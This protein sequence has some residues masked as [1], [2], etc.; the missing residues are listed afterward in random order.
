MNV[1]VAP[2]PT[3]PPRRHPLV[4]LL[5][6][7]WLG[8]A[9]LSLIL[10]YSSVV[11]AYAPAR[12]ALEVTEM[13]A[14]RHWLFALLVA[15]FTLSLATATFC[16]MHWRWINAGALVAH[17]GLLLLVGGAWAYF[18]TKIEGEVLLRAPAIQIRATIGGRS[19]I[20]D[21]FRASTGATWSS[22]L[23][24]GTDPIT[25]HVVETT[26][27]GVQP[28][29]AAK[30]HVHVGDAPP[31]VV[32]VGAGADDWQ[33]LTETLSAHLAT[34]AAQNGFYDD[35]TPVL[36]L[37]NLTTGAATTAVIAR[38][39]IHR[40]RYLPDEGVLRDARGTEIPSYRTRPAI[41]LLGL[42]IPT[43]WFEPWRMPID[44]PAEG[45]PFTIRITGYV[46]YVVELQ[47]H[48][49]PDG[50]SRML[51]TLEVRETRQQGISPRAASA[52]RLQITGTGD[53]AGWTDTQWCPFSSY[54]EVN[55]HPITI[56]APDGRSAWEVLYTRARHN[57]GAT[58]AA[59]RVS[60]T[61]FPGQRGIESYRSDVY[62]QTG[63]AAPRAATVSTNQ[64]LAI[65]HWTLFQSGFDF[66]NHWEYTVLGVGNQ[67]GIWPMNIGWIIVTLGCLFAFY[68]KPALLRRM[69]GAALPVLLI[70]LC[71]FIPACRKPV[72]PF[73]ASKTAITL[74]QK[75]DWTNARLIV[76]QDGGRYKTLD[77]FAR[78]SFAAMTGKEH[79]PGLT[80]AASLLEWLFHRD[81][82]VDTPLLRVKD[83]GLRAL[84]TTH[85]TEEKRRRIL[86]KP[87]FTPRELADPAVETALRSVEPKPL[88]RKAANRVRTAQALAANLERI[89]TLVPQPG[90]DAVAPWFVPQQVLANLADDQLA[91]LG[92]AR[93]AQR[94]LP[95]VTPEQAL[96]V[97]VAW[98]SLR[99]AWL[100]G[101]T[102]GVQKYLDR[103]S[104]LLPTLAGPG[105]YPA[106]GQRMAEVRYYALGKFTGG[107]LLYFVAFLVS[108]LAL[109]TRWRVPWVLTL[110][111]LAAGLTWHAY[112]LGLR[113]YILGRVPVA[114]VFEAV[115]AS[116]W[117][118]IVTAVLLE[119]WLKPRI[120]LVAASATGFLALVAAGYVLP[121]GEL[122]TIPGILDHI[123]LR[124]HTVLI[125]FS[126]A[127]IFLAAVIAVAYLIGYYSVRYGQATGASAVPVGPDGGM[128]DVS[129]QRPLLA[130]ATPGDEGRGANLPAW[131]NNIDWSHL[132]ILNLVFVMLF[133]G[134]VIMGAIWANESW[135]RP[136]GWD[137]K[138]VFAL[139]TW[140]IYAIL[141]HIRFVV[142]NRGLWTAWLSIAGCIM[143]AFN[144]FFV[145]F[146]IN[147]IHSYA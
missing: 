134:G 123:Q 108:I 114:N 67:I 88:M 39:P 23:A 8:V 132:I 103:L 5:S 95:G 127:L 36:H 100:E 7:I 86:A 80:P 111:L 139:N 96:A 94:P 33:P 21:Q 107:W 71:V 4:R 59:S 120:L 102:A 48:K 60:A 9:L 69:K 27:D 19:A 37:R 133:V 126:Y 70:G 31:R 65:G 61:Y 26:P 38:L 22:T 78:E 20:I 138:E 113:W 52:I 1:Q 13:Q 131:L 110:I 140:I 40:E 46:P 87:H 145:N 98:S 42:S 92:L 49:S 2:A 45:L 144:W 128:L 28:V 119:L 130:G 25:I 136:W 43:G 17:L 101:D 81:A 11:S 58:I 66:Q 15:L 75:V 79:L 34:Y 41:K 73:E 44:V 147:S 137:P 106:Q 146:F 76:V 90:G 142:R 64:T 10:I 104:V 121:G 129:R 85:M 32:A 30:L 14:F 24:T 122:S 63:D 56:Q 105:V 18:G 12:W 118:G 125:S 112:G 117:L 16:R 84:L 83:I 3:Q 77:S 116:A 53:Y 143:M 6:S 62:V 47:P 54:V 91:Q 82:Y 124:I 50:K 135:G 51:P 29:A 55:A 93:G 109:V 141:I 89:I 72:E 99:A 68:V 35:E 97:T 115:V 57:L 74:D